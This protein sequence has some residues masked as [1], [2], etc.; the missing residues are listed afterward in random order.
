MGQFSPFLRGIS[1]KKSR[2]ISTY[3]YPEDTSYGKVYFTWRCIS[4]VRAV[5]QK[6]HY[7]EINSLTAL[8]LFTLAK[9]YL[10]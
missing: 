1:C 2:S 3:E 9:F 8:D 10:K 7:P 6:K 5:R 4:L